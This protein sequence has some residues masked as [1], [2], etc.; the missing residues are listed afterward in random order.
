MITKK[1]KR[2]VVE[3]ALLLRKYATKKQKNRLS[4]ELLNPLN[5]DHC[6]YGQMTGDC[7]NKKSCSLLRKCAIPFSDSLEVDSPPIYPVYNRVN[8]S[9]YSFSAIELYICQDGAKISDLI[10]LIKS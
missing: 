3:E 9:C 7:N 6:I 2:A 4:V 8:S 1:L 10:G 5:T